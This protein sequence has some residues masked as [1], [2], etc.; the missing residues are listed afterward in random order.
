MTED[1]RPGF[2]PNLVVG[3]GV[4]L[5]GVVLTLDRLGAANALAWLRF[6]PVLVI[7]LGASI[8]WQALHPDPSGRPAQPILSAPLVVLLVV[9]GI[10]ASRTAARS[11]A[12]D[13]ALDGPTVSVHA[14]L[15]GNRR[16]VALET[17]RRGEMTAVMGESRL[18][19]RQVK[20]APGEEAVVDVVAIMGAANIHVPP[21]WDVNFDAVPIMGAVK[22]ERGRRSDDADDEGDRG[23]QAD[24]APGP[25]PPAA[26]GEPP[27]PVG[28]PAGPRPRLVVRGFVMMGAITV[29]S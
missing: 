19:L 10:V 12:R 3:I 4:T 6:W 17:F 9:A 8:V 25:A 29:R 1:T 24:A 7:L 26:A 15:S 21:D 2:T 14:V 20:L 18:D 28:P 22:D 16:D 13:A 27:G 5:F 23:G 11:N